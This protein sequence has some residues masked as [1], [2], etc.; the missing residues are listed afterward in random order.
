MRQRH[1]LAFFIWLFSSLFSTAHVKDVPVPSFPI[2]Q[3]NVGSI[4]VLCDVIPQECGQLC[5]RCAP[6]GVPHSC[7]RVLGAT[8]V[9]NFG[10]EENIGILGAAEMR[11]EPS[12]APA[13]AIMGFH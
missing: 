3:S 11:R 5:A 2:L 1:E 6:P 8:L 13:A 9:D 7:V 10:T 4:D 12:W